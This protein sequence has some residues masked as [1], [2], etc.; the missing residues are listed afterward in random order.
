MWKG[1]KK[2]GNLFT[3]SC[4]QTDRC[5]V[6]LWQVG[7]RYTWPFLQKANIRTLNIR[8]FSFPPSLLWLR[9]MHTVWNIFWVSSDQIAQLSPLQTSCLSGACC[10][11]EWWVG[12]TSLMLCKRCSPTA[13]TSACYQHPCSYKCKVQHCMGC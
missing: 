2:K 1:R 12:E 8:P 5:P 13:K 9:M 6:N 7:S 4:Q 11:S 10:P 3:I